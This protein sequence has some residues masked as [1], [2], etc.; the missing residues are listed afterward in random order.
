M[1]WR[2]DLAL[3]YSRIGD[4]MTTK[5]RP[6]RCLSAHQRALYIVE[7]LVS[8]E[9][10]NVELKRDLALQKEKV[11]L[12]FV[13]LGDKIEAV[14]FLES[15]DEIFQELTELDSENTQWQRDL[16]VSHF[17]LADLLEQMLDRTAEASDHWI[18]ALAIARTLAA[19]DHLLPTDTQLVATLEQRLAAT[20]AGPDPSR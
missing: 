4:L 5:F 17:N 13:L 16:I 11:G 9:P 10:Y 1:Q 6:L 8:I 19:T 20:P 18:Q 7:S 15:S 3:S 2:R 14:P 12:A